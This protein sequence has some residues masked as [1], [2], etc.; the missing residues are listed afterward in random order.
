MFR[1]K[2]KSPNFDDRAGGVRPS[3]IILHYTGMKSAQE[4]M[5]RLCDP[6]SKVSAHY[7]IDEDGSTEQLV[8][9]NKRAWHAGVSGWKKMTDINSHSIGVEIVNPGHE[10]GYRP[11]P[12][13]QMDAVIT[14]C[15]DLIKKYDI[16]KFDILGHSD[17]APERK[18]DPGE[19]FDWRGLSEHG[20]GIWPVPNEQDRA[21]AEEIYKHDYEIEH[22]LHQY[23]YDPLAAFSDVVTAFHRHFYPEIFAE[24]PTDS[25]TAESTARL[26]ALLCARET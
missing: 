22:L 12:G 15:Q 23:G 3:L 6:A 20:V 19:L 11:F 1:K 26:L 17:V 13:G 14:L 24:G 18:Q 2:P 16:S 7:L 21:R 25:M 8:P 4:A 9:E 5:D 10:N